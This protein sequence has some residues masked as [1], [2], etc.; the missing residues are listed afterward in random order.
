MPG[1]PISDGFSGVVSMYVR[2]SVASRSDEGRA[3]VYFVEFVESGFL[4]FL[5]FSGG[6]VVL[7]EIWRS[8]V[9]VS[10]LVMS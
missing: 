6:G 5:C 7:E 10:V 3:E 4:P 2:V 1:A 9:V 8:W